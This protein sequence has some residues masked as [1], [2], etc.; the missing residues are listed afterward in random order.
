MRISIVSTLRP[1]N[2]PR[3]YDRQAV[4]WVERGHDVHIV[5]RHRGELLDEL[6][7]G[8]GVT[9]LESDLRGW[10]RRLYLGWQAMRCVAK[11]HPD[12]VHYHDPELHFWLPRLAS[13]G[14]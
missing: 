3:L 1:Y 6:P 5:A 7:A 12:V 10:L 8:L 13:R 4:Q 9:R 2:E 11:I 14:V